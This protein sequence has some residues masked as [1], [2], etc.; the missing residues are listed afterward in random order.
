MDVSKSPPIH[1]IFNNPFI[2]FHSIPL[3]LILPFYW[4]IAIIRPKSQLCTCKLIVGYWTF[5]ICINV[6]LSLCSSRKLF[7]VKLWRRVRGA[8]LGVAR[9]VLPYAG[10]GFDVLL[11][12]LVINFFSFM[13]NIFCIYR[14]LKIFGIVLVIL[15]LLWS[16][17]VLLEKKHIWMV[18]IFI[19]IWLLFRKLEGRCF[20]KFT[21]VH[22]FPLKG[23]LGFVFFGG[24][25]CG[26]EVHGRLWPDGGKAGESV[27]VY[28]D[29]LRLGFWCGISHL[30]ERVGWFAV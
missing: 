19:D 7:I 16:L 21:L 28:A 12:I 30:E 3:F 14:Y 23:R 18:R 6:I 29:L 26:E 4:S 25:G 17:T 20:S 13:W 5:L 2:I 15:L 11:E 10:M 9:F 24:L 1:I 27:V 22:F 8:Q